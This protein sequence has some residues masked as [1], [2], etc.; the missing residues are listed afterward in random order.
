M[1]K[2]VS[3]WSHL[4]AQNPLIQAYNLIIFSKTTFIFLRSTPSENGDRLP[5]IGMLRDFRTSIQHQT[6]LNFPTCIVEVSTQGS[7]VN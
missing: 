5:E 2:S 1:L 7:P 6:Q 4:H 3:D